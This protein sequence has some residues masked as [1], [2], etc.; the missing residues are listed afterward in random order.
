MDYSVLFQNLDMGAQLK[1]ALSSSY[2]DFQKLMAIQNYQLSQQQIKSQGQERARQ[3]QMAQQQYY[4]AQ[5][6]RRNAEIRANVYREQKISSLQALNDFNKSQS[7]IDENVAKSNAQNAAKAAGQELGA[8]QNQAA[9]MAGKVRTAFGGTAI[10]ADTGTALDMVKSVVDNAEKIGY[11]G[12][13]QKLNQAQGYL[14]NASKSHAAQAYQ[15][16]DTA[17]QIYFTGLMN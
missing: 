6:D 15:D 9:Q 3:A 12:Y 14:N 1:G 8:A 10:M 17:Q 4:Q 2:P 5:V 16:F 11:N 13:I 7:A